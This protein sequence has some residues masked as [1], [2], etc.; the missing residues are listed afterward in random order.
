M[1]QWF[2]TSNRQQMGP[3]SLIELKEL[4]RS[5][6][7]LPHDLVWQ[8]GMAEW[9]QASTIKDL[10]PP[11]LQ[12]SGQ[13]VPPRPGRP[14]YD[15][16]QYDPPVRRRAPDPDRRLDRYEDDYEDFRRP[17]PPL[18]GSFRSLVLV[19][20]IGGLVLGG[21][22]LFAWAILG[23]NNPPPLVFNPRKA[24]PPFAV[25]PAQQ[26]P[27]PLPPQQLP[28]RQQPAN[29]MPPI[30]LERGPD[31]VHIEGKL[32]GTDDFALWQVQ[33][34][35]RQKVYTYQMMADTEYTI[36]MV[37]DNFERLDPYLR[38]EDP[39]GIPLAEND[40]IDMGVNRNAQ[41]IFRCQQTGPYR[42]IATSFYPGQL[43]NFV[44]KISP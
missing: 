26:P 37:S 27:M 40:D 8:E 30:P 9:A 44:L 4:A 28:P 10:L 34:G 43:A 38:L 36:E 32:D 14:R 24:R 21:V 35:H 6:V 22:V 23:R 13:A 17:A 18:Y 20:G 2:F 11:S 31:P 16:E 1:S 42:I 25:P 39:K 41:I 29:K 7:L 33:A 19:L 12:S 3:V 5:G 15:E